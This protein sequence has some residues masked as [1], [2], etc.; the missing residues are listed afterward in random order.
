MCEKNVYLLCLRGEVTPVRVEIAVRNFV[1][2]FLSP[3]F[4]TQ[5]PVACVGINVARTE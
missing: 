3:F 2:L 1:F 4:K 5:L